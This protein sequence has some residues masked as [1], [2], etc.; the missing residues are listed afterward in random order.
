MPIDE[1][2]K[3]DN[4]NEGRVKLNEAINQ[5]NTVQGQLDTIIIASGTSDAET[6][7]ARGGQPLLYN[8]L[9]A[10]DAQLAEKSL[11]TD[12]DTTNTTVTNLQVNKAD[13]TYVDTLT[14]SIASGSP[15]PYATLADIETAFPTG[16]TNNYLNVADGSWYYWNG[17]EWTSG[18]VYQSTGIADNSVTPKKTNFLKNSRNL[19]NKSVVTTDLILDTATG[20][21]SAN[22]LW[23]VSEYIPI[24]SGIKYKRSHLSN[25]CFYDSNEVFVAGYGANTT[26][27]WRSSGV[28]FLRIS[29]RKADLDVYQL[30]V[31]E[32]ATDYRPYGVF[33]SK[34]L[35]VTEENLAPT[36]NVKIKDLEEHAFVTSEIINP[37]NTKHPLEIFNI[38]E[39]TDVVTGVGGL[40]RSDYSKMFGKNRHGWKNEGAIAGT[41][42]IKSEFATP[43]E[44]I[45]VG[46]IS[47]FIYIEDVSKI[48]SIS[49]NIGTDVTG[50]NWIRNASNQNEP[51]KNGMNVL[52]WR[53][54]AGAINEWRY[55]RRVRVVVVTN[56]VTS[57]TIASIF[58]EVS[59]KAQLL[60]VEDGGYIEFLELG[61]PALKVRNIPTTWA[62]N[63]GRL[64]EVRIIS[65]ADVDTLALDHM[66]SF[67]FHSWAS[68]VHSTM[69]SIEVADN[70]I[71]C[72]RWLQKKGIQPKYMFRAAITQN[73]CP[74]HAVLQDMIEAYSSPTGA[75][76]YN[77][78]PFINPY[79]VPRITL[80]GKTQSEMDDMFAIMKKT[81][82]LMIGYTHGISDN[83]VPDMSLAE[84][85]YFLLKIDEGIA[86]GWLEGVTYDVLRIRH[87]R[88]FGGAGFNYLLDAMRK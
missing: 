73:N 55:F 80:H 67:S 8:R 75:A 79:G 28:S 68:E 86:E 3:L 74:E 24:E 47:M 48:N 65:E 10:S 17:T 49:L 9:D 27:I 44:K 30:E 38:L 26:S 52:R 85:D 42:E 87:E 62:L 22:T 82:N 77:V 46:A 34:Y 20:G 36:L 76:A 19:F 88:Q 32:L 4:L 18:G 40:V 50:H 39:N 7:Q 64:G 15:K 83:P 41:T 63:P 45:G 25:V 61:Y 81:H 31:G 2:D 51:L 16:D 60:F 43:K 14:A 78:F 58:G 72:M 54:D 69:T 21:T 11:Q 66:S 1:I 71:K 5:A 6:I 29:V 35:I 37:T 12:L 13:I 57:W 33:E 70:A 56:A 53:A 59:Q 23:V 84:W